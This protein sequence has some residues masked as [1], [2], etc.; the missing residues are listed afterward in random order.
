M[1]NFRQTTAH[2]NDDGGLTLVT[3]QDVSDI[4]IR[5]EVR[6]EEDKLRTTGIDQT[7]HLIA[8]IPFTVIDE[9]NKLKIMTGFVVSDQ[10]AFSNWLNKDENNVW[11]IYRGKL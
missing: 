9:L 10:K 3:K 11:K 1:N 7:A 4:I 5:N 2:L 6:R 8:S